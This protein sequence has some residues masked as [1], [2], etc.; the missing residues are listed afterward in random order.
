MRRREFITLFGA[1]AGWPLAAGAVAV[2]VCTGGTHSVLAALLGG[3]A[4]GLAARG[5][6]ADDT[7][8]R[9]SQ[10][11]RN[12]ITAISVSGSVWRARLY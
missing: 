7:G 12:L 11:M 4:A 5:R 1:A 9:V 10:L 8:G 3:A 6:R 2:L